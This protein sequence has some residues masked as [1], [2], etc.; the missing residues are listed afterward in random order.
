MSQQVFLVSKP[1]H[2]DQPLSRSRAELY[3]ISMGEFTA[4]W[5]GKQLGQASTLLSLTE[6]W[7]MTPDSLLPQK[8]FSANA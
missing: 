3:L 4:A 8:R 6:P 5:L 1:V 7:N 2:T